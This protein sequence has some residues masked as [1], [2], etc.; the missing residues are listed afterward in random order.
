M[1]NITGA[2]DRRSDFC[3]PF[4]TDK[5]QYLLYTLPINYKSYD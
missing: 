4:C 5:Q 1:S 2:S 3:L